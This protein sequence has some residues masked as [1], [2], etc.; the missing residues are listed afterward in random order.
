MI[1][2]E[3]GDE[4]WISVAIAYFYRKRVSHKASGAGMQFT[5]SFK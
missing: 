5:C 1:Q 2:S 3:G 4:T